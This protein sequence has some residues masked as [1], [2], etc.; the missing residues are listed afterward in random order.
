MAAA[1]ATA[2]GVAIHAV[3]TPRGEEDDDDDFT[4][5]GKMGEVTATAA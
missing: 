4:V 2:L 1:V 3:L 5:W